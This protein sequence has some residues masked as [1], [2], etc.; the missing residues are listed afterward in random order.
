MTTTATTP[1]WQKVADQKKQI[2][3]SAEHDYLANIS[4]GKTPPD[5]LL[6][7]LNISA[8]DASSDIAAAKDA[9]NFQ[10]LI[11]DLRPK[12]PGLQQQLVKANAEHEQL[13]LSFK[14]SE[15]RAMVAKNAAGRCDRDITQAEQ[16]LIALCV[17]L[18]K[19]ES[20]VRSAIEATLD[21]KLRQ[22]I[23]SAEALSQPREA[24][25][26]LPGPRAANP[27]VFG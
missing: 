15:R 1:A 23:D 11:T 21:D 26:E 18:R 10:K 13:E 2:V 9:A 25:R 6:T 17:G 24:R 4:A 7:A 22:K 16:N 3:E 8:G 19:R 27:H 14:E 5:D 12:L 20:L